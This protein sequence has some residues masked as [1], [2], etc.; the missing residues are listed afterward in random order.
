MFVRLDFSTWSDDS[1]A[2]RPLY[3]FEPTDSWTVVNTGDSSNVGQIVLAWT[4]GSTRLEAVEA[5]DSVDLE[6]KLTCL[7]TK[8]AFGTI[9]D[10]TVDFTGIGISTEEG[11]TDPGRAYRNSVLQR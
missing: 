5:Q 7:I 6:G 9:T 2:I 3:S 11:D 8:K 1:G 4:C 10:F